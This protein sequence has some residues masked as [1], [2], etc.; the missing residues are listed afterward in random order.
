MCKQYDVNVIKR[1][2][3]EYEDN[4]IK[5]LAEAQRPGTVS[6]HLPDFSRERVLLGA[7]IANNGICDKNQYHP[8]QEMYK[9]LKEG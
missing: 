1:M 9:R 6:G 8:D 4:I 7:L 3:K 2:L 5:P